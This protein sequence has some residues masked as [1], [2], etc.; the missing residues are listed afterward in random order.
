MSETATLNRDTPVFAAETVIESMRLP[1]IVMGRQGE[2]VSVN[3]SAEEFLGRSRQNVASKALSS[4]FLPNQV[5]ARML[6]RTEAGRS[7]TAELSLALCDGECRKVVAN[8]SP[9][10]NGGSVLTLFADETVRQME[11]IDQ[12]ERTVRSL[13]AMAM[14]LAHEV[15]NPLSGMRGAAQLILQNATEGDRP[16]AQLIVD[17]C[18]RVVRLVGKVEYLGDDDLPSVGPVNIHAVLAHVLLLA[19]KGFA[20]RHVFEEKFDPSLP[21]V[22]GNFDQLVQ[23]F[24]NLIKNAAEASPAA[25]GTIRLSTAWQP[26]S[27]SLSLPVIVKVT[28]FGVGIPDEMKESLFTLP[29]S[30][31]PDGQGLGLPI[32]ARIVARH[33]GK[34]SV[35]SE[36]GQTIFSIALP[37]AGYGGEAA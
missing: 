24:L 21:P 17:E 28:D 26:Q 29:R 13:G 34:I 22:L 14:M 9:L 4:L 36:P 12:Q 5:L 7:I 10:E 8:L 18:D 15:K 27:G 25:G 19:R 37:H 31:K 2:I 32:A 33:K 3:M 23:L 35:T 1:V 11:K 20:A 6:A 16:L 30:R